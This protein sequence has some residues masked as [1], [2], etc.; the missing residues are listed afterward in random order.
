VYY[1][2]IATTTAEINAAMTNNLTLSNGTVMNASNKNIY[3]KVARIQFTATNINNSKYYNEIRL[4]SLWN[5][6]TG[7]SKYYYYQHTVDETVRLAPGE[8]RTI[9][10]EIPLN[11]D[12]KY[13]FNVSYKTNGKF[14]SEDNINDTRNINL[15]T[16]S[17]KIPEP[18]PEKVCVAPITVIKENPV[19]YDMQGR[20][21]RN[22]QMKKGMYIINGKK[23]VV[24]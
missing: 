14:I 21:I 13:W 17:V 10:M 3:D 18:T 24:K 22:S 4:R 11:I 20:R 2:D 5:D 7:A 9:E 1:T 19:I 16:Y 6:G 12:G 23:V 8:S 15:S